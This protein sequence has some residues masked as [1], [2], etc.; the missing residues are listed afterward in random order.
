[1]EV[2][3]QERNRGVLQ[4]FYFK[5]DNSANWSSNSAKVC[6]CG[7]FG[8]Q[9]GLRL[10]LTDVNTLWFQSVAF[11]CHAIQTLKTVKNI[12][13]NSPPLHFNIYWSFKSHLQPILHFW[14]IGNASSSPIALNLWYAFFLLPRQ[15]SPWGQGPHLLQ[16]CV[17]CIDQQSVWHIVYSKW[18]RYEP[19]EGQKLNS[20][21]GRLTFVPTFNN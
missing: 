13:C 7:E 11:T 14:T 2:E 21:C 15:W 16:S 1:M 20:A 3:E 4:G 12:T 19:S 18:F 17:C 10:P 6:W 8:N 5:K 9:K